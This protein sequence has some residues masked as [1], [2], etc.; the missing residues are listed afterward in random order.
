MHSFLS[1]SAPVQASP[2]FLPS[3]TEMTSHTLCR[4][5]LSLAISC[6]LCRLMLILE[7]N[8]VKTVS[9]SSLRLSAGVLLLMVSSACFRARHSAPS[10]GQSTFT[11]LVVHNRSAETVKCVSFLPSLLNRWVHSQLGVLAYAVPSPSEPSSLLCTYNFYT[12]CRDSTLNSTSSGSSIEV[13]LTVTS[14][15]RA[16][17]PWATVC[18]GCSQIHLVSVS[19]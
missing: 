7:C 17:C 8:F 18:V 5:P 16:F 15:C 10:P 11:L 6:L 3:I 9:Q 14:L 12:L 2:P 13:P 1:P 19:Y 4:V